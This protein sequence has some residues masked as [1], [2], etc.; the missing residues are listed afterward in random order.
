MSLAIITTTNEGNI[1]AADSMETYR[2][3]LGDTREG[4]MTRMKL[5]QLTSR[6]GAVSCGLAFLDNKNMHQQMMLFKKENK[7]EGLPVADVVDKLYDFFYAKYQDYLKSAAERKVKSLE[8]RGKTNIETSVELEVITANFK[9]NNGKQEKKYYMPIIEMLVAGHDPDGTNHVYKI[10]IPDP[11]DKNGIVE[12]SKEGQPGATWIGQ[13]EVL[14][15]IIR[16]WSPQIKRSKHIQEMPDKAR[17]ELLK[18]IDDQEY[19]VNWGTMTFQDAIEFAELAIK[20]TESI[21]RMT[22][23]TWQI[24]GASPGVGG[25][26]DIAIITPEKGFVWIKKKKIVVEGPDI[27]LDALPDLPSA[28][29]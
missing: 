18:H 15:R 19:L 12:K 3:A 8:K 22:D 9:D 11:K 7:L 20:T 4:S 23:G 27:D 16:G 13:T 14:V 29:A 28:N 5:F 10:V 6:I 2:N 17:N 25:P 21:Q 24:P 1:L 26:V